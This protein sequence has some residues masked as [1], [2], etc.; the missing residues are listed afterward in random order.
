M[1]LSLPKQDQHKQQKHQGVAVSRE[2]HYDSHGLRNPQKDPAER[3]PSRIMEAPSQCGHERFEAGRKSHCRVDPGIRRCQDD[4]GD[5]G[6]ESCEEE[7]AKNNALHRDANALRRV[8]IVSGGPNGQANLGMAPKVVNQPKHD[9]EAADAHDAD[10]IQPNATDGEVSSF[11]E[12]FSV[13]Q[14]AFSWKLFT[15]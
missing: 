9:N 6:D 4:T 8:P 3:R 2:T 11:E 7:R 12:L 10:C 14:R 1:K 13:L 5:A 15:G